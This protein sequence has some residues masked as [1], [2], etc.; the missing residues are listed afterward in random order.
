MSETKEP[1]SGRLTLL[2]EFRQSSE[3][4]TTELDMALLVANVIDENLDAGKARDGIQRLL[5]Q[6]QSQGVTDV[7]G[8]AGIFAWTGLCTIVVG[9]CGPDSQQH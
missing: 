5:D 2:E 7:E 9:R 4:A 8:T 3:D 1:L 6:A